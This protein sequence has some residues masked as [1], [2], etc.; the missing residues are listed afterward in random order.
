MAVSNIGDFAGSFAT[1]LTQMLAAKKDDERRDTLAKLQAKVFEAQL[2]NSEFKLTAQTTLADIMTGNSVQEFEPTPPEMTPS[3]KV[4]STGFTNPGQEPLSLVDILSGESSIAK[5]GQLAGLQSGAFSAKDI[6]GGGTEPSTSRLLKLAGIFPGT[7][8]FKDAILSSIDAGDDAD[9]AT[10]LA[11]SLQEER[12]VKQRTERVQ[13]ER[14]E[15][16]ARIGRT[17][18]VRND[19]GAAKRIIELQQDLEGSALAAG[20]PYG[21]FLRTVGGGLSAV[22]DMAGFDVSAA[23]DLIDKRDELG[24]LFADGTIESIDRFKDTGS[25]SIP[26]WNALV[27][28]A[29]EIGKTAIAN[30]KVLATRMQA[31]LDAAERK[32]EDVPNRKEI[33]TW[34]SDMKSLTRGKTKAAIDGPGIL[35]RFKDFT[36][37]QIQKVDVPALPEADIPALKAKL[38]QL[39]QQGAAAIEPSSSQKL[40]AKMALLKTTL[41][42]ASAV[43]K[44][45]VGIAKAADFAKLTIE[46]IQQIDQDDIKEWTEEQKAAF[47]KRRKELGL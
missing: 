35:G 20:L 7:E 30:A 40:L 1:T 22:M 37:E 4:Q 23:Q 24:K 10:Q 25:I 17:Q 31:V 16:E 46:E 19:F 38:N 43:E 11:L 9:A 39:K 41:A 47:D 34:I 45:K 26:K 3:G 14:T 32:S 36:L 8:E 2:A 6:T 33:E 44:V 28:S 5:E 18:A 42:A 27:A 29:P 15:K 13:L 12:L 21:D